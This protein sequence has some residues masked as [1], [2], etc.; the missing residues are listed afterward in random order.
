MATGLTGSIVSSGSMMPH[1]HVGDVVL[2]RP[3]SAAAAPP[4]GRVITFDAPPGSALHGVVLH[5][6]VGAN[7]DGT[8][9]TKGDAN[10]AP[11]STPLARDGIIGQ[12]GILIPWVGL[13]FLWLSTGAFVQFGIWLA[14]S[15]LAVLI[16]IASS[17]SD[18]RDK[19][20]GRGTRAVSA[21]QSHEARRR[22][23][24]GLLGRSL[25]RYKVGLVVALLVSVGV[26]ASA[27]FGQVDASFTA[28]TSSIGSSWSA[29]AATAA[30]SL[31]FTTNPSSSTGGIALATQP[32][33]SFEDAAGHVTTNGGAVTL[34]LTAPGGATL[35]CAAN[36]VTSTS[37]VNSFSGCTVDKAGTYTLTAASGA[38]THGVSSSFVISRG[39]AKN[40][41]FVT[42]PTATRAST[43]FVGTPAVAIVDAGGNIVSSTS[44][45]TLTLTTVQGAT[46]ICAS[47]PQN[48]V[49]GQA[50]FAGCRINIP[51]TFSLTVKSPGLGTAVSSSFVIGGPAVAPLTCLSAVFVATFSWTPTPFTATQYTLYVNG[52]QVPATGA[53]GFNSTVQLSALNVPASQ[54]PA[55]TATLEVRKVLAN[56]TEVVI[57]DGTVI[58]GASGFRTYLCG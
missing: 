15:I 24:V 8:L 53:D 9:I 23:P 39:T 12:A 32:V 25:L 28:Q 40:L 36:P 56:G 35:A 57:G 30:V 6:L 10:A 52:I 41:Q 16:E 7:R 44:T 27:S 51:G 20:S 49:A 43:T 38:L 46:L 45:V 42:S 58:L 47:N 54:F 17:A 18:H 26:V 37:G 5:R 19:R 13:P 22:I 11:D 4:L 48:A 14:G 29:K 3:F 50:S 2:S 34:S 31:A 55:G 21:P 33:V 1:I